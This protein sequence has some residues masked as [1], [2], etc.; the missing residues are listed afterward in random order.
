MQF[1]PK[2]MKHSKK[3]FFFFLSAIP[4][5]LTFLFILL[6]VSNREEF[7]QELEQTTYQEYLTDTLASW[8]LS[9]KVI[10]VW[11]SSWVA[12][13]LKPDHILEYSENGQKLSPLTWQSTEK[14]LVISYVA[15]NAVSVVQRSYPISGLTA[16]GFTTVLDGR[17]AVFSR[18]TSLSKPIVYAYAQTKM[19]NRDLLAMLYDNGYWYYILGAIIVFYLYIAFSI[20]RLYVGAQSNGVRITPEQFPKAYATFVDMAK[21]LGFQTIP[22]LYLK[23]G[24]GV[25]NAYATCIPGYRSFAVVH[26]EIFE[27]YE[28]GGDEWVFRFVLGHELGHIRMGHVS[29]LKVMLRMLW[30]FP[31]I[32]YLVW[33]PGTRAVEYE[34][35]K[36]GEFLAPGQWAKSLLMLVSGNRLYNRIDVDAYCADCEKHNKLG[37]FIENALVDHPIIPWR[38]DVLRHGKKEGWIFFHTMWNKSVK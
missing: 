38:V 25:Y 16:S 15:P 36:V 22:E 28:N 2:N 37:Y 30:N 34:A 8:S 33:L 27:V 12:M 10:G 26:A 1:H 35:D 21:Q 31:G 7:L 6:I 14:N 9:D 20:F 13:T 11:N 19:E 4:T 18:D 24:N 17:E 5:I 32:N 23:N 29:P 3:N